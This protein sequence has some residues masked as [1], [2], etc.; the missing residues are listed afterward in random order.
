M[1]RNRFEVI[2]VGGGPAGSATATFLA[3]QGHSVL[4]LERAEVGRDKPCGE[5]FSPPVRG[6][7]HDLGAYDA[8]LAAG[9]RSVAG[10]AIR[11]VGGETFG[12]LLTGAPSPWAAQGAFSMERRVLDALLWQN[13]AR[14]G[15]TAQTGVSVRGLLRGAGGAV[16]GVATDHGDFAASVVVGAD[17]A[18]SR[19]AREMGVVRPLPR[20][21]KIGLVSHYH[22]TGPALPETLAPVEM[23]L[24]RG[25]TECGVGWGP[26]GTRNI[27]LVVPD[28]EAR[29][30]AASGPAAYTDHLLQARFPQIWDNLAGWERTRIATRGT[31][32]HTTRTPIAGG[33]LLVGDAATFIDP[34]TGE[35]VYF[36]LRSAQL[37]AQTI[38]SALVRG[39]TTARTG[40]APYARARRRELATKY[41]VCGLVERAVHTPAL[42]RRVAPHFARRA[43]AAERLLAVTGDMVSPWHL[44]SPA[45]LWAALAG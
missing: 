9:V 10:A 5:F 19:V 33:V 7:L 13:A 32:G 39:D 41:H 35:G 34:F 22:A 1:P 23:H 20:L 4:L 42:M 31:F 2:V 24:G 40:L 38:H 6:L 8:V 36:A 44:L 12:G 16:V 15:V 26:H 45:W 30:V 29:A 17:G 27:T 18:K 14:H 43:W 11:C 3:Q 28:S 21:Q 25:K 37:A